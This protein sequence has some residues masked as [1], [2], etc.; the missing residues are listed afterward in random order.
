MPFLLCHQVDGMA[1]ALC[2]PSTLVPPAHK[3]R[4]SRVH[5]ASPE[6]SLSRW[7]ISWE[8][9]PGAAT[10]KAGEARRT[11]MRMGCSTFHSIHPLWALTAAILMLVCLERSSLSCWLYMNLLT[12]AWDQDDE[13]HTLQQPCHRNYIAPSKPQI[14]LPTK[15]TI[16]IMNSS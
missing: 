10:L 3:Q 2:S 11:S 8:K 4:K 6:E 7:R 13:Q 15:W 5:P 1:L 14:I 12:R 16:P 9:L